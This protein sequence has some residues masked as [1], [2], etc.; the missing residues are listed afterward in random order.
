MCSKPKVTNSNFQRILS[1]KHDIFRFQV[2]VNDAFCR[3]MTD[4]I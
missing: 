2:S 3:Q 4:A 1:S